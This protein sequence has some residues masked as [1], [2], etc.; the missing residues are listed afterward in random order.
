MQ[1]LTAPAGSGT[2]VIFKRCRMLILGGVARRPVSFRIAARLA[3]S[4]L[5]GAANAGSVGVRVN[6]SPVLCVFL[7]FGH[8]IIKSSI[9][10]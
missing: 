8:F 6:R 9:W 1:W 10:E 3:R 4:V 2:S 5:V 7:V